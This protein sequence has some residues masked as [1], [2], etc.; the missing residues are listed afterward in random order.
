MSANTVF[1]RGTT[2]GSFK[3]RATVSDTGGSGA[4]STLSARSAASPPAGRSPARLRPPRAPAPYDSNLYSWAGATTSP[5]A[6]AH[7]E[8]RSSA[9][10][11]AA[12][13][14]TFTNDVTA[15]ARSTSIRPLRA[16]TTTRPVGPARSPA[17]PPTPA[18]ASSTVQVAIQQGA[19]NYYD[20][21]TFANA[22]IT[23]PTATGTSAW[24]YAIAAAK[25]TTG[26]TYTISVR[27]TDNVGNIASTID[28]DIHV[29]HGC[30]D[31]RDARARR[32]DERFGHR[33]DRLLPQRRRPAASRSRSRSPTP[34]GPA[35]RRCSS[36][37]SR[38]P[39]GRTATRQ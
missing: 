15:P 34:V 28:A 1:Y 5:T 29:R 3:V 17:P 11:G 14:L 38:R 9:T 23:W 13:T 39:A 16:P 20:G 32:A 35:R 31:V 33:H 12:T 10:A 24:S 27:S 25:L 8:R 22:G 30:A 18:P 21:S 2:A 6:A 36:R 26:N 4:A 37:R 19:G 7:A